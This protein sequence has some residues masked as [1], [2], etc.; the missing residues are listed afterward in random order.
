MRVV[1]TAAALADL[2]EILGYTEANYPS[3]TIRVEHRIRDV[4]AR[5]GEWP[6]NARALDGQPDIRV[7]PLIRYPYKIF[8]RIIGDT[9]EILHLHHTARRPWPE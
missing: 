6:R 5:I 4:I 3:L 7:V 2:D 9:V 1:F 8:Y